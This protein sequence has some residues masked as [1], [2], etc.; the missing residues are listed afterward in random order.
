MR[1]LLLT[2]ALAAAACAPQVETA[3]EPMGRLAPKLDGVGNLHMPITAASDEAQ[4]FFNQG[5]TLVYGFNHEEG[6]R[7]FEEA[8]RLDPTCAMCFWGQALGHGPNINDSAPD[9]DRERLAFQA[10]QNAA[11]LAGAASEKEQALIA[12]M[13]CRH[14][15]ANPDQDER[16]TN[17]RN[18]MAGVYERFP[19]DAN[20]ATLYAASMMMTRPWDYWADGLTLREE[21]SPLLNV[22]ERAI[23][24]DP[25]NPGPHHYYIH[26]VE[27]SDDP[28]RAEASADRLG[29]LAPV[30]GHLVHMPSHIY[31]RV[32]RYRDAAIANE[33]ASLA[34]E[35]YIAQCRAQ[36]MYPVTYYPHNVHFLWAALMLEG[37]QS[38]AMEAANKVASRHKHEDFKEGF[39]FPHLLRAVPLFTYVRFGRWEDVLAY[40]K[41]SGEMPFVQGVWHFARGMAF[42]AQND[43]DAAESELNALRPLAED[44]RVVELKI[45]D[46]NSLGLLLQIGT[47]TLAGEIEAAKGNYP[48]AIEL[49]RQAVTIDD[50][51]LY[52]EPRDWPLPPRHYLGA[53]LLEANRP[54]EAELTYRGDLKVHPKNAWALTG[55]VKSLKNQNK[56]TKQAAAELEKVR[57][58][59]DIQLQASRF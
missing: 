27:A 39:A 18:A 5:L 32:G 2:L 15:T 14:P 24:A 37:R 22:L 30:A 29:G 48:A 7:A 45:Y 16:N 20:V 9:E 44:P 25:D 6:I 36:G 59:A 46:I 49:L 51:L 12:A 13:G 26:A 57:S 47:A 42:R 28:E 41:P 17:Y 8:A 3:A 35:D 40:P 55:V 43:L 11:M 56:P 31:I 50:N 4:T 1:A 58:G 21:M 23:V 34:D 19:G 54:A 38:E 33:E 53:I 10:T 52:S